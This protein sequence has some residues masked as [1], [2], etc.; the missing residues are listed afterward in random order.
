MIR[1]SLAISLAT[2]FILLVA[3][4]VQSNDPPTTQPAESEKHDGTR[5]RKHN[6]SAKEAQ[7]KAMLTDVVFRGTWSMTNEAGLQGNAPLTKPQPERYSIKS[8][9]KSVGDN[10]VITAQIQYADRDVNVPVSVRVV[11]AGDTPIITLDK[12]QIPLL[13]TYSARV[14]VHE[15]FYAGT[16]RGAGYGGVL[17]GQI[18]KPADEKKIEEMEKAGFTPEMPKH[19]TNNDESKTK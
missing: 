12:M 7:F 10:W 14:V 9:S 3:G 4:P 1:P 15:G 19:K 6:E 2:T 13:G 5:N 16:W 18:I 17:S 11:W 8:V